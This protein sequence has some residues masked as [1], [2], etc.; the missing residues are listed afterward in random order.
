MTIIAV[1]IAFVI[2]VL[3]GAKEGPQ[4]WTWLTTKS[5]AKILAEAQALIAAE[6]AKVAAVTKAKAVVAAAPPPV[7]TPAAYGGANSVQFG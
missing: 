6:E 3:L 4:V 5:P 2:G 1:V 7:V